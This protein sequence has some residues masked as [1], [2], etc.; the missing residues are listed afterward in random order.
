MG[1][2]F[3]VD[4]QAVTDAATRLA[5]ISSSYTDISSQLMEKA[6]TMGAAWDS[7][8]NLAF[9]NRISGFCDDLKNMAAKLMTASETLAKQ[10]AQY[11]ARCEDNIAQVNKLTN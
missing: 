1:K 8:D 5:D 4:P 2:T 3:T 9:V 11:S 7:E 10:S 6:Q